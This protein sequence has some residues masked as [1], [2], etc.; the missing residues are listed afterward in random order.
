M[1][2][3]FSILPAIAFAAVFVLIPRPSLAQNCG[4]GNDNGKGK[5]EGCEVSAPAPLIG[6]GLEGIAI[7]IGYGGYLL[8][9]RRRNL[10]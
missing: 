4:L 10:G 1:K 2:V 9:R 8:A 6:A 3:A 5:G 7:V